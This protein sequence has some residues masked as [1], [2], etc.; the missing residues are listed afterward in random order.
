MKSKLFNALLVKK[1][2][3][4]GVH[5]LRSVFSSLVAF[6]VADFALLVLMVEV[7]DVY[8]LTAA[9]ISFIIGASVSYY[10]SVKWVFDTRS[11][12]SKKAEYAMFIVIGIIGVGLNALL[13]WFF[14]ERI[15][16]YYLISK[17]IAGTTIFFFNFLVRKYTLFN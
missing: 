17:M 10:L 13:I 7:F 11:W 6:F 4:G 15:E 16:I 14:T 2:N 1:S 12:K 3:S 5:L 8:Y 9:S